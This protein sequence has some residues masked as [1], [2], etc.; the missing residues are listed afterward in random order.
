[1]MLSFV[2]EIEY[3]GFI[4]KSHSND[5]T[6][7]PFKLDGQGKLLTGNPKNI[8]VV[9]FAVVTRFGYTLRCP[10]FR[11]VAVHFLI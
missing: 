7:T 3:E 5:T 2:T 1:M 8:L 6:Y 11:T 9:A 10:C 4:N